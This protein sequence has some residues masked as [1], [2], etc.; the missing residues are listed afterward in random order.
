MKNEM[1]LGGFLSIIVPIIVLIFGWGMSMSSKMESENTRNNSQDLLIK[2]SMDAIDKVET[3]VDENN[4][5]T[6]DKLDRILFKL[7]EKEDRR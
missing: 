4:K 7:D 3:K 1:T 6:S 2:Q 5:T